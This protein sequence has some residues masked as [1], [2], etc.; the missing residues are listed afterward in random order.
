MEA[1]R[2]MTS[3]GCAKINLLVEPQN[4]YA[5]GFHANR[6]Y[7]VDDLVFMEKWLG[8]RERPA[9]GLPSGP[10]IDESPLTADRGCSR[11]HSS[12]RALD[13]ALRLTVRHGGR[14]PAAAGA[15]DR[16][17]PVVGRHG[18]DAAAEGRTSP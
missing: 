1:E 10:T 3:L 7:V 16:S 15:S 4:A 2:R 17:L 9:R 11:R 13:V 12:S 8:E 6:G 18:T 5:V 14:G